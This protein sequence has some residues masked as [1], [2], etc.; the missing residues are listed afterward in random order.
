M[1]S[2]IHTSNDLSLTWK[3]CHD[4]LEDNSLE[5]YVSNIFVPYLNISTGPV[6]RETDPIQSFGVETSLN[7][8]SSM[9]PFVT[10]GYPTMPA[11]EMHLWWRIVNGG[12]DTAF[13]IKFV[14]FDIG[15]ATLFIHVP[16]QSAPIFQETGSGLPNDIFRNTTELTFIL[17]AD[18]PGVARGVYFNVTL[19]ERKYVQ[20]SFE[21]LCL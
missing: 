14:D 16:E 13:I 4:L 7:E 9:L 12:S 1:E 21:H 3:I 6:L 17:R 8:T 19:Y 2:P 20:C 11:G 5:H 18:N 10:P 15:L